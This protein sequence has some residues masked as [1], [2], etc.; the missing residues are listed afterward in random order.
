[1]RREGSAL[2][3]LLHHEGTPVVVRAFAVSDA[4][5]LR[6]EAAD[7]ISAAYGIDRM[8]FALGLDHDV[9]PFIRAF[10]SHPLLRTSLLRRPWLR[11]RRRPEPFEALAWAVTE[12][13]IESGRAAEIQRRLV[14]RHGRSHSRLRDA[15]DAAALAS[16]APSELCSAGLA[17]KRS[18]AMIRAAREVA[19]GRIDLTEH[20][21]AWRRLLAISEVG[22]WTIDCLALHGQG[23][24]DRVPAGD[25]AYV[26]L[27]G[28]MEKL[29]RRATE[30]EVREWFE[31]FAP[32]QALAG[33][34][35]LRVPLPAGARSYTPRP[36]S[37][38]A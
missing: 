28:R 9:R 33:M 25:L 34:H 13:L 17:P 23:R 6:A 31:P 5:R 16:R 21:P 4:V 15:P 36:G 22:P 37:A 12:Q 29:G 3:R 27:V 35:L 32:Y 24:D 14:F 18:L 11:P 7:D 30:P 26:V 10:R 8:R 20:E 38:A 1:M 2:V 19:R